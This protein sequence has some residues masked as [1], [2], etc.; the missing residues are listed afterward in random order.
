MQS[1]RDW[2]PLSRTRQRPPKG[3]AGCNELSR[4]ADLD[5][6]ARGGVHQ[7]HRRRLRRALRG[8]EDD[9]AL[10]LLLRIGFGVDHDGLAGPELLPEDLLRHRVLDQ[11]LDRTAQGPSAERRVVALLREEVLGGIRQL[12]ADVLALELV[13]DPLHHE[14]DDVL[15]V[16]S[17]QFPEDDDLVD[18]VEELR[19]EGVLQLRYDLL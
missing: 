17:G 10:A 2:G 5:C 12:D 16:G 13:P 11:A 19:A 18:T 3:G 1:V 9:P 14:I 4:A 15:D 8:P 6:V 7:F